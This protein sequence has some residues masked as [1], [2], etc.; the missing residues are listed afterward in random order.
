MSPPLPAKFPYVSMGQIWLLGAGVSEEAEGQDT[1][2]EA[3]AGGV[4][5]AA[6]VLALSGASREDAGAFLKDQ[7][8]LSAGVRPGHES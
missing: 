8:A 5:P 3:V 4:D 6:A 7:R 2:A 1:G